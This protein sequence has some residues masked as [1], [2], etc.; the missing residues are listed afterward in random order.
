MSI[1]GG[2]A[3]LLAMVGLYSLMAY[4][5]SLRTHEFGV[6]IALGGTTRGMLTLA[7]KQAGRLT[8]LGLA[9]GALLACVLG[10]A[11]SSAL[12]GLVSVDATTVVA[13]SVALAVVSLAAAYLPARRT[14]RLDPT[15]ILRG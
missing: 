8:A 12:F 3:G 15:A 13:V 4:S 10:W 1:C 2:I 5:I 7:L 14:L 9:C 11:L 6:R